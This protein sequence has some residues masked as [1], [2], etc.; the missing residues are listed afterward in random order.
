MLGLFAAVDDRTK[1]VTVRS[2]QTGQ[3]KSITFV[4][5]A[6]ALRDR[7]GLARVGHHNLHSKGVKKS[8]DPRRMGSCL[9]DHRGSRVCIC[10]L[11]KLVAL[12][13]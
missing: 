6:F 13:E 8:T 7:A 11:C 12:V 9:H 1:Q 3:N 2:T 4:T 10:Q 5:L